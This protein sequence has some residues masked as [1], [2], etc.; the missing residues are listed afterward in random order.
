M[1]KLTHHGLTTVELLAILVILAIISAVAVVSLS[2]LLDNTRLRA[3]QANVISLN[4]ATRLLK[5]HDETGFENFMNLETSEAKMNALYTMGYL[6]QPIRMQHSDT[7]YSFDAS[8]VVWCYQQ[9]PNFISLFDFS[10]P[11]FNLNDFQVKRSQDAFVISEGALVASPPH[12]SDDIIFFANP[13]SAYTIEVTAQIQ[14]RLSGNHNRGGFGVLIETSL[15]NHN[16]DRDNGYIVQLDR[17][18]GQIIVRPRENGTERGILLRYNVNITDGVA[19]FSQELNDADNQ[20]VRDNPWWEQS[21]TMRLTVSEDGS[22]K[23]LSVWLND[24]FVFSWAIPNPIASEDAALNM[25]GLR[26]WW[27]VPVIF[28]A[29]DI[30]D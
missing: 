23:T 19:S 1:K 29:F 14:P 8:V 9:C 4:Q 7:F 17:H 27:E 5:M 16:P 6:N 26:T 3:D 30:Y 18:V 24:V 22:T 12:Q 15:D 28:E 25:T 10:Q 13:R 2:T 11:T 21:H 20:S